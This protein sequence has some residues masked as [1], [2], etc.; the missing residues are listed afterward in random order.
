MWRRGSGQ[1]C[2][3]PLRR[4]KSPRCFASWRK[5]PK[6]K[7][8]RRCQLPAVIGLAVAELV[9]VAWAGNLT[10]QEQ[11]GRQLYRDGV[12]GGGRSVAAPLG[13]GSLTLPATRVPCA[14]CHGPDGVGQPD[15]GV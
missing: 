11:R 8:V 14:S 1:S 10:P 3:R 4:R 5:V 13:P 2:V 12:A 6:D 7:P 15:A 9:T